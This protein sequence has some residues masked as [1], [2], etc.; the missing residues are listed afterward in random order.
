MLESIRTRIY[1]V[2]ASKTGNGFLPVRLAKGAAL[3]ANDVVG[4]PLA[5]A[6]ELD[7]R[8][9]TERAIAEKKAAAA[10]ES[11]RGEQ[12]PIVIFH[13][14]RHPREVAKLRELLRGEGLKF[15]E[16]NVADDEAALSAAKM[17]SKFAKFPMLFIA[18]DYV[19]GVEALSNLINRKE[20]E[21]IAWPESDR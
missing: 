5:P 4:R 12:A 8:R 20:L 18:G 3:Y 9:E 7:E 13:I 11:A 1:G 17:D 19:G 2:L 16:R 15:S 14:D 10:A 6:T 21:A